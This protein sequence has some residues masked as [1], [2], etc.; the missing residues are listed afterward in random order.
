MP[1][2]STMNRLT[3]WQRAYVGALYGAQLAAG[4]L[5]AFFQGGVI[6]PSP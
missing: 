4:V 1:T 2:S 6:P 3:P 5:L